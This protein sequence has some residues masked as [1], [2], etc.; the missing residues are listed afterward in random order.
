MTILTEFGDLTVERWHFQPT[1]K[2]RKSGHCTCMLKNNEEDYD[3]KLTRSK[4]IFRA[5]KQVA[6]N[7]FSF[8]KQVTD[9]S[10]DEN[11]EPHAAVKIEEFEKRS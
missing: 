2:I 8:Q 9:V 1:T 3:K 6:R 7:S 10:E 11:D 4:S 5:R